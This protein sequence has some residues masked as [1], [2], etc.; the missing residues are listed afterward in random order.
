M[1]A[2][3]VIRGLYV[4]TDDRHDSAT[5][6]VERVGQAIAGG[7][8]IVQYRAKNVPP[9]HRL[10][11]ATALA[12]LCQRLTIPLIINDD[13]ELA[14]Q[15]GAAGVHLGRDDTPLAAARQQ[16]GEQALI[17]VSCYNRLDNAISAQ[18]DGADYVA[19]GSFFPSPTKPGAVASPLSLLQQ[20]RQ[21][22]SIPIVAIGGITASN[23]A[24]LIS[25]GASALAVVSGVFGGPD[26]RAAAA[27]YAR[28]FS[29][30][31]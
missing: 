6:L 23:G 18:R 19:F 1:P 11:E 4:I 16:L 15:V 8:H 7:A 5:Q 3:T 17:G 2:G 24:N 12:E 29:Q 13:I 10:D 27:A 30:P 20:A 25:A 14:Q 26:I 28:L 21:H 9:E 31:E 22:L